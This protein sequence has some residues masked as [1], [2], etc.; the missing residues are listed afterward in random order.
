MPG[1]RP[2]LQQSAGGRRPRPL[3]SVIAAAHTLGARQGPS[4]TA[5]ASLRPP[6]A[7]HAHH[8]AP[9]AVPHGC[10]CRLPSAICHLPPA[11]LCTHSRSAAA[12][13][14]TQAYT[15]C[16][17]VASSSSRDPSTA[18]ASFGPGT[19]QPP[20]PCSFL[21]SPHFGRSGGG[22]TNPKGSPSPPFWARGHDFAHPPT[23]PA[24]TPSTDIA[25]P[26][27]C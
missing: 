16:G 6:G 19:A 27:S 9:C 15:P 1:S 5:F 8:A 18:L 17:N 23:P 11:T 12:M 4:S 3:Q 21:L 2:V 7:H 24:P 10:V 26:W 22:T 20:L 25:C 14:G 13:H